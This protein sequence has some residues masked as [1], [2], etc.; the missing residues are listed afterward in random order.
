MVSLFIELKFCMTAIYFLNYHK[1]CNMFVYKFAS[2]YN[3][4]NILFSKIKSLYAKHDIDAGW[5][6]AF[7]LYTNKGLFFRCFGGI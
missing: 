2:V 5:V 1:K 6:M 7:Q 3:I 4:K